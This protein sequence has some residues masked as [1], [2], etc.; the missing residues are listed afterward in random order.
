MIAITAIEI[1]TATQK[2]AGVDRAARGHRVGLGRK[3]GA[4]HC[5]SLLAVSPICSV[6]K[7]KMISVSTIDS[8]AP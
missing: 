4:G 1:A 6:A 8:A 7:T 2:L 5:A 3:R